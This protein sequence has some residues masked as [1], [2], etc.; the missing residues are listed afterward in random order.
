MVQLP[1]KLDVDGARLGTGCDNP[2]IKGFMSQ[3]I[4]DRKLSSCEIC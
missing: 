4:L 1:K 3:Q 2:E